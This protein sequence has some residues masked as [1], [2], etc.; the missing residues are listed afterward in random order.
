VRI[1][2]PANLPAHIAIIMDGNG[3]WAARRGLPRKAGHAVGSENFRTIATF[4]RDIGIRYLTVYAL[5]TENARSRPPGEVEGIYTLLRKYL[6]ESLQKMARDRIRLKFFGDLSPL[7][8]DI[9]ALIDKTEEVSR[10]YTGFQTNICLHY[11]GR[12]EI[13]RAV[14][15]M[16]NA[17]PDTVDEAAFSARLD[18][19]GIP[20]P[21][22]CIRTGGESRLS[23]FL[24]W[25]LAYAELYYTKTLW[26]GFSAKELTSVLTD[27]SRRNRRYGGL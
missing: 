20:D 27:F 4:C 2:L 16:I 21:D 12:D 19:A 13:L 8:P 25:Q 7:P 5:S 18:T 9:R 22:L 6:D 24:L 26:P 11:G 14:R 3:R 23:N 15:S 10:Q 17:K 1:K